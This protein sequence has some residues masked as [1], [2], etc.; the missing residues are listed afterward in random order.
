M[1][2]AEQ[3]Q[4]DRG[5]EAVVLGA[6][7]ALTQILT[8]L[9]ASQR[10]MVELMQQNAQAPAKLHVPDFDGKGDV[11]F[12]ITQFQDVANASQ[13]R[14]RTRLLKLRE[15]LIGKATICGRPETIE[16]VFAA[17]RVRFGLTVTEARNELETT[18]REPSV[19]L[20]DHA[21]RIERLVGIAYANLPEAD[22]RELAAQKFGATLNHMGIRNLL[23]ARQPPDLAAAIQAAEEYLSLNKHRNRE[24]REVTLEEEPHIRQVEPEQTSSQNDKLDA[25]LGLM[26][27]LLGEM[28]GSSRGRTKKRTSPEE[29]ICWNCHQ[30]GHVK[31]SCP[32]PQSEQ[33]SPN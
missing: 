18:V 31:R 2:G 12:F 25:L 28:T 20:R 14:G 24:V 15:A 3:E 26:T 17:L 33:V 29:L 7:N 4:P 6:E 5:G 21:D 1:D 8:Q 11:E 27:R 9:A 23:L 22:Q 13:W 19:P 32:R 10:Q 16:E 30:K